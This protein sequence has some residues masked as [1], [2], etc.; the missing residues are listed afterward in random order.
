MK[1]LRTSVAV[2]GLL[3][4]AVGAGAA[5][6]DEDVKALMADGERLFEAGNYKKAV[7]AYERAYA[8]D[9]NTMAL[10][11][12]GECYRKLGETQRAIIHYTKFRNK[13]TDP[14]MRAETDR[15]ITK[16]EKERGIAPAATGN[17]KH[18]KRRA[19]KKVP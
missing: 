4:S 17:K 10:F 13:V 12:I 16:L 3:L 8:A 6:A 11:D 5:G 2:A 19:G 18:G 7:D 9:G 14:A 15:L 1:S